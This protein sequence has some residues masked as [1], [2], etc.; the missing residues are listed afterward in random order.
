[1]ATPWY[2]NMNLSMSEKK[3]IKDIREEIQKRNEIELDQSTIQDVVKEHVSFSDFT[4]TDWNRV[5][6]AVCGD[7]SK[8]KGPRGGWKFE[9]ENCMYNCFNCGISGAFTP[10]NEIFM[11]RD[12]K[13]IFESFG[14]PKRDYGKILFRLR[15][16]G[17]EKL[18]K[19]DFKKETVE[20]QLGEGIQL[21][22]YLVDLETAKNTNIGRKAIEFLAEEK[23]IDYKDHPFFVTYGKTNSK[24][25]QEKINAKIMINRLVIPIYYKNKLLLLQGRDLDGT[26][27][28]KYINIGNVS[29]TLYGLDR[30][31]DNHKYIFVTEGFF[32]AYHLN[33]VACITNKLTSQKIKA[34]SLLEKDK[35]IVPDRGEKI[36]TM[37]AKGLDCGWGFS[38]PRELQ[39][40]KDVTEAIKKYGKLYVLYIIMKSVKTGE[41]AEFLGRAF[42]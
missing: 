36:N 29:S 42:L 40:C 23:C 28:K 7:G 24:D 4:P 34:L 20:S 22:D 5:Y 30:L 8:T 6:C 33:G 1:M 31:K 41:E 14:I 3:T 11:S 18:E 26:K 16:D 35:V 38:A 21:P 13:T 17:V 27:K 15:R 12:M 37:L 39:N 19:P 32:D 10:E 9:G 25:Q 2:L